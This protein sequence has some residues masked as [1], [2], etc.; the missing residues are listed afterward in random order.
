M[1]FTVTLSAASTSTVTVD[2]ATRPGDPH[3]LLGGSAAEEQE[4]FLPTSGT[5]TFA[6][7]ETTK[8]IDVT[9][10]PEPGTFALVGMGLVGLLAIRRKR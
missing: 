4:D 10:V 9:V 6:P 5:L 3:V 7:G 1:T 8:T 2:F